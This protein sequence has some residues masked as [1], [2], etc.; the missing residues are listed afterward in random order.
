ML[1]KMFTIDKKRFLFEK[2]VQKVEIRLIDNVYLARKNVSCVLDVNKALS[3]AL[4]CLGILKA[5]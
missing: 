2:N 1:A 5:A 4:S 3:H